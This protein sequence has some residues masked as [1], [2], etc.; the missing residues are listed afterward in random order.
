MLMKTYLSMY[1]FIQPSPTSIR[2]SKLWSLKKANKTVFFRLF[3][4]VPTFVSHLNIFLFLLFLMRRLS[5]NG[6]RTFGKGKSKIFEPTPSPKTYFWTFSSFL[7]RSHKH[8]DARMGKSLIIIDS[9]R[10]CVWKY[11]KFHR[12]CLHYF[13]KNGLNGTE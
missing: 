11:I 3:A 7:T 9:D 4:S 13:Q 5:K 12:I 6:G 10:N 2:R 1:K 8:I